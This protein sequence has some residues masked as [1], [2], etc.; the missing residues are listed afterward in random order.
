M[1]N[2]VHIKLASVTCSKSKSS[3]IRGI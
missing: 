3:T 1:L 2:I